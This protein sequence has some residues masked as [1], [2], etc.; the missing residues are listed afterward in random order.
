MV[1][2][3]EIRADKNT[4]G[5]RIQNVWRPHGIQFGNIL[6]FHY[7]MTQDNYFK[8]HKLIYKCLAEDNPQN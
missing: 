5:K 3:N 7:N 4:S 8:S 2:E 1:G 6:I